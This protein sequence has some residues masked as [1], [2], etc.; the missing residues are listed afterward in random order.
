MPNYYGPLRQALEQRLR[1]GGAPAERIGNIFGESMEVPTAP[2]NG[3][4]R[5]RPNSDGSAL[6][7]EPQRARTMGSSPR[8]S[9][10][11]VAEQG[12]L[13]PQTLRALFGG[14]YREKSGQLEGVI[15]THQILDIT[16]RAIKKEHGVTLTMRDMKRLLRELRG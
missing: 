3:P 4:R 8:S 1:A 14:M 7:L 9:I 6:E 5:L 13:P 2:G 12:S 11:F 15:S 10:M 16:R